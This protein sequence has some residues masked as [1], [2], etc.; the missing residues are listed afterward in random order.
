MSTYRLQFTPD[1]ASSTYV[2]WSANLRLGEVRCRQ[3]H[4]ALLQLGERVWELRHEEGAAVA[5][6]GGHFLQR[7]FAEVRFSRSWTLR[8]G[9]RVLARAARH[10]HW[11]PARDHLQL[12]PT[13]DSAPVH[14]SAP[15]VARDLVIRADQAEVGRMRI[16]GWINQQV[17]LEWPALDPAPAAL[18]M[19]AMHRAYGAATNSDGA[20]GD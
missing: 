8:D 10:W 5:A 18:F 1:D 12:W 9:E 3:P 20:S 6:A 15:G 11:R 2:V 19:Y 4:R 16:S 13:P 17:E 7:V 14:A